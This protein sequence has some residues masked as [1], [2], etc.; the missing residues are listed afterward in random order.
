MGPSTTMR[1]IRRRDLRRQGQN[2]LRICITPDP[3]K[4]HPSAHSCRHCDSGF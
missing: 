2:M 3:K 4:V 1:A